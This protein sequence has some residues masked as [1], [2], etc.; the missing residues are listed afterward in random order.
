MKLGVQV[1]RGGRIL[2]VDGQ[3]GEGSWKLDNFHGRQMCIIPNNITYINTQRR[4]TMLIITYR[5][6]KFEPIIKK[7]IV[8]NYKYFIVITFSNINSFA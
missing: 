1:Q 8:R 6:L 5:I 2:D 7:P 4:Q 3:G